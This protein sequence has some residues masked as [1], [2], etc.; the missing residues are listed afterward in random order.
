L[1]I[2][3]ATTIINGIKLYSNEDSDILLF[4]MILR[5]EIDE[6]SKSMID[7]LK[8]TILEI[9]EVSFEDIIH[10]IYYT[11]YIAYLLLIFFY[12]V[13]SCLLMLFIF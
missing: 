7:K 2:D 10:I 5:N 8:E 4:G 6:Q 13:I 12:L 11:Y 3:W 9:L 1:I